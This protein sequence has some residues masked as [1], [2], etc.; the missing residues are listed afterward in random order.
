[1]KIRCENQLD[2]LSSS[3]DV[4]DS[5][6]R[7]CISKE[8]LL[9]G[10]VK[11]EWCGHETQV[12]TTYLQEG[13][14]AGVQPHLTTYCGKL[15]AQKSIERSVEVCGM[16]CL[17]LTRRL[18]S[19]RRRWNRYNHKKFPCACLLTSWPLL[20]WE[21]GGSVK[22]GFPILGFWSL[23]IGVNP[24]LSWRPIDDDC[25]WRMEHSVAIHSLRRVDLDDWHLLLNSFHEF[26][27]LSLPNPI[28]T[29]L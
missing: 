14:S 21:K 15:V 11:A 28:T 8:A 3:R 22:N 17:W 12:C 18:Y 10:R 20:K 5:Y 26:L 4:R 27:L 23:A 2:F 9:P 29:E 6:S 7:A 24:V 13:R 19:T 1:M 16:L 25:S